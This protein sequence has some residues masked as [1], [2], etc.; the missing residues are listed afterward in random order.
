MAFGGKLAEEFA[1]KLADETMEALAERY[2]S[3]P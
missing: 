1:E 3:H 2:T